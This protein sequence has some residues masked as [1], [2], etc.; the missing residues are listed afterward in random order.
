VAWG[1]HSIAFCSENH[2]TC[3]PRP[4]VVPRSQWSLK[5]WSEVICI[6]YIGIATCAPNRDDLHAFFAPLYYQILP[7]L[8]PC[9]AAHRA[10][11]TPRPVS[12][13]SVG[14]LTHEAHSFADSL[15]T[16]EANGLFN[17]VS[18]VIVYVRGGAPKPCHASVFYCP[19]RI[20][21]S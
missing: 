15:K 5:P 19:I 4:A 18:E 12:G 14:I 13:V 16:Y 11:D 20:S 8:K 17:I 7:P 6:G 21:R 3:P 10:G 9:Q 1:T 2:Q